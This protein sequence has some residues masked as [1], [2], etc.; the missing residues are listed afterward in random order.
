MG[1]KITLW[2]QNDIMLHAQS[3]V[4]VTVLEGISHSAGTGTLIL[5]LLKEGESHTLHF[6][7]SPFDCNLL[8]SLSHRVFELILMIHASMQKPTT[9][10]NT[11][12]CRHLAA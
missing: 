1:L 9:R 6:H 8:W 2:M 11:L 5:W 3:L 7:S 12:A 10:W 4:A